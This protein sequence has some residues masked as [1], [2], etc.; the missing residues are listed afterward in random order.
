[1]AG[2]KGDIE[3][4]KRM[5]EELH[6]IFDTPKQA[7]TSMMCNRRHLHEWGTSGKTPCGLY[8]ARLHYCGGDVIYVLTGKRSVNNGN[9]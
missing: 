6:R 5:V 4:G 2:K 9:L 3:I 8:L 1:M 7:Y